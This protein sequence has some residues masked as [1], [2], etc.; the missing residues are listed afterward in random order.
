MKR[1][2]MLEGNLGIRI[3]CNRGYEK[4]SIKANG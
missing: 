3:I 4:S 1:K 2:E